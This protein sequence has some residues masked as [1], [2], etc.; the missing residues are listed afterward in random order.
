MKTSIQH[1]LFFA[2]PPASVWAYLTDPD[3]MQLWL[4]KNDFK[5][6]V[7]HE[8]QFRTN[9]KADFNFDGIFYCKVLDVVP[10]KK[11][12]YSWKCGPGDGKFNIDSVVNWKLQPK[13]NGT[14]LLLDHGDFAIMDNLVLFN[15]MT[16][17]WLK[18]IHK[19]AD[20][21]NAS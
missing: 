1:Q 3:L 4:M 9:P 13:D 11:L 5:P 15:S 16:E 10:F 20:R 17:G 14:L 6:V 21:L 12:S 2:H 19:M 7:G 8:F 18:N